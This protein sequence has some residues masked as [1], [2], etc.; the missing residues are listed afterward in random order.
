MA[1]LDDTNVGGGQGSESGNA[2][3]NSSNAVVDRLKSLE[4]GELSSFDP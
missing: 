4:S 2:G 1:P 3:G